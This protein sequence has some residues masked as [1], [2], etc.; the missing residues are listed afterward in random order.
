MNGDLRSIPSG[1]GMEAL[2]L[3]QEPLKPTSLEPKFI[4]LWEFIR[5]VN[6]LVVGKLGSF[7]ET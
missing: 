5:L 1:L 7:N 6:N 4:K 2:N 3:E